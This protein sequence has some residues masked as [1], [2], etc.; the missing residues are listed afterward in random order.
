MTPRARF[1]AAAGP[2]E[3]AL[4]VHRWEPKGYLIAPTAAAGEVVRAEP[5]DAVEL[6]IDVMFGDDE[7]GRARRAQR[8]C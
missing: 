6:R 8:S 2:E 4:V 1:D 3:K 7:D 5:F